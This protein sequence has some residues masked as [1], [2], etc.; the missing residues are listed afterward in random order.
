MALQITKWEDLAFFDEEV[1]DETGQF[2]HTSFAA[3]DA[4]DNAYFG[5]L[6]QTKSDI[7]FSQLSTAL[8]PIPD[9]HL[10]PEWAPYNVELTKAPDTLP[11]NTHVKHPNLSTYEMFQEHN[12]LDLISNGLLEEVK[13]WRSS[14]NTL[15]P[16]SSTTMAAESVVA[17]SPAS[18]STATPT[19]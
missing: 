12:V 17:A 3:F 16:T 2:Q 7:I 1:D 14:P 6:N 18:S 11:P 9:N 4:D 19:R 13:R 8:A 5:K 15:T 10:F